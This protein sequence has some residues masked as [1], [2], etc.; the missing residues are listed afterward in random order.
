METVLPSEKIIVVFPRAY[1]SVTLWTESKEKVL[2]VSIPLL[3]L[4]RRDS[5][6]DEDSEDVH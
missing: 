5:A 2:L 1:V 6:Q 4:L 3:G